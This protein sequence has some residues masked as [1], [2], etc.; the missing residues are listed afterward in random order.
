MILHAITLLAV[1]LHAVKNTSGAASC[2]ATHEDMSTTFHVC[3]LEVNS[4]SKLN[5]PR[6]IDCKGR[7]AKIKTGDSVH[8]LTKVNPVE[9]IKEV[10][11]NSKLEFLSYREALDD[12]EVSLV[13]TRTDESVARYG[14][15]ARRA[16]AG[17]GSI[18]S[19]IQRAGIGEQVSRRAGLCAAALAG[20]RRLIQRIP[21]RGKVSTLTEPAAGAVVAAKDAKRRTGLN[22]PN[23]SQLPITKEPIELPTGKPQR[24]LV[25]EIKNKAMANV[26]TRIAAL[27]YVEASGKARGIAW[28]V[29]FAG[30]G[31]QRIG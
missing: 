4:S 9:S 22:G 10:R 11:L 7:L 3:E 18:V 8:R 31:N 21:G 23:S 30:T 14:A 26:E 24:Y 16:S 5:H 12:R 2:E 6:S 29:A 13:E 27:G 17:A 25:D 20:G 1:R 28:K 15:M 19:C